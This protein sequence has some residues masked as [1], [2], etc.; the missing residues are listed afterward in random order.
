MNEKIEI[1]TKVYGFVNRI[2]VCLA[3]KDLAGIWKVVNELS[4]Y[5]V[6]VDVAPLALN[7]CKCDLQDSPNAPADWHGKDCPRYRAS[8]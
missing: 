6:S 3:L 5:L 4:D 2:K 1:L 7:S 8:Q